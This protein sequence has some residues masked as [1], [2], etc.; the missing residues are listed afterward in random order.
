M[1]CAQVTVQ[2]RRRSIYGKTRALVQR[3]LRTALANAEQGIMPA[4]ERLTV[5]TFFE[6]WLADDVARLDQYTVKNY[7]IYVRQHIVPELG[8]IR[9][10]QLQ[11]AH[12]Q[13]L[14]T[15]LG[16]KGLAPKTIRNAH[17]VLRAALEKAVR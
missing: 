14:Y 13:A 9:L 8:R 4:P 6:R 17:G 16:K 12:V 3:K 2:G 5:E 1:W 10:G 7:T 11:V 15:T